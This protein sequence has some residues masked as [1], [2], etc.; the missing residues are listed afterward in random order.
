MS[1]KKL[2]QAASGSAGGSKVYVEDVFSTDLYVGNGSN[3]LAIDNGIDLAGEGGLVWMK[4]RTSGGVGSDNNI[5]AT[6]EQGLTNQLS[7]DLSNGNIAWG[8]MQSFDSD[9]FTLTNGGT[10]NTNAVDYVSWTFRKQPGFFDVKEVTK[11]DGSNLVVDF[12]DLGSLGF[13]AA[14]PTTSQDWICWCK[15]M[16][17]THHLKFNQTDASSS[18]NYMTVGATSVTLIDGAYASGGS[19]IYAWAD[20]DDSSAQIFGNDED[21]AIIKTGSYT[22]SGAGGKTITLGFEPQWMLVKNASATT[23]W[24]MIDNMRGMP[25][26]GE[27]PR[28]LANEDA[29]E[30]SSAS[31]FAPRADGAEV[32]LQNTYVNTSGEEYIYMA[33]RRGPMK[34]PSAGTDVFNGVL[35]N[36]DS[37]TTTGYPVDIGFPVDL[38]FIGY[39]TLGT[40]LT[41]NRLMGLTKNP[42]PGAG[43]LSTYNNTAQA[44]S[45]ELWGAD[46]N[47]GFRI[48]GHNYQRICYGWRRYPKVFDMV[49]YDGNA[50]APMDVKHNLGVAAELLIFKKITATENWNVLNTYIADDYNNTGRM[51]LDTN[52]AYASTGWGGTL[53]SATAITVNT[54]YFLNESGS[55]YIAFLFA[56]LA[57]VSKV[58]SVDHSGSTDVDCGF[59]G[60]ARF[61]MVKRS[62][63][64]GDWFYWDTM[65]GI[66]GSSTDDPYLRFNEGSAQVTNTDYIEPLSSGFTLTSNFTAGTY[67]FLA[68]A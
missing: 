49:V 41:M 6:T 55:T 66:T 35:T 11:S 12:S 9:G 54:S 61:V 59:S 19:I 42:Q 7:T 3:G 18:G 15:G 1:T 27:G 30:V 26:D 31:Y 8:Q 25:V 48:Y 14:K 17:S 58:G 2:L 65:R 47:T 38:G 63:S 67:L 56:S 62:D 5:L 51:F 16:T 45:G 29:A 68:F 34:E 4:G 43:S 53:S 23:P 22:G 37:S 32:T 20:G 21:E 50:T 40:Q 57:G 13:V 24:V 64:T 46:N 33:I 10:A 60:G 36:S 52:A 44:N 28:L 39:T